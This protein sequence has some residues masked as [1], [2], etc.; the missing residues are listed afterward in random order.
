M[1]ATVPSCAPV[2]HIQI[3]VILIFAVAGIFRI[4]EITGVMCS[5]RND[6][7]DRMETMLEDKVGRC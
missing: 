1:P 4:P 2:E 3:S 6:R 5:D 7:N